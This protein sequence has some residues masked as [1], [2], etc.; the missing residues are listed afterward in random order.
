MKEIVAL[1]DWRFPL[2]MDSQRWSLTRLLKLGSGKV[3][4]FGKIN[5][6]SLTKILASSGEIVLWNRL[7]H[8]GISMSY[9]SQLEIV[10]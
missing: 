6:R 9:K 5:G 1:D 3:N 4:P 10:P 2:V 8:V 7:V